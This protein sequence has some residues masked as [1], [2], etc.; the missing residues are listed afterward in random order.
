MAELDA[1][2]LA[3]GLSRRMGENKL[4]LPLG[5][6]S[7]MHI[8]L[9]NFPYEIF[10]EVIVVVA[11]ERVAAIGR[12]FPVTLCRNTNPEQ[13]KSHSI[14]LGLAASAATD[15]ILFAVADQP[16]LQGSTIRKLVDVFCKE[17]NRIVVPEVLGLLRNPVLFPACLRAELLGLH[18]DAGG[19]MVIKQHPELVRCVPFADEAQFVDIDT[20]DAYNEVIDLWLQQ[21]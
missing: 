17:K 3:S 16:F 1:V 11:D 18:G 21:R 2:I 6:S 13:G 8:F 15:G 12:E 7:V 4:L 14:R 20:P 5:D 10:R 9:G 19:R